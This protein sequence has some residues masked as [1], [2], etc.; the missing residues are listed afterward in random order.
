VVP[1]SVLDAVERIGSVRLP[2]TR[3]GSGDAARVRREK[4]SG[5]RG[6]AVGVSEVL[7]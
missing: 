2:G 7:A 5:F 1:G 3:I 6:F 4:S